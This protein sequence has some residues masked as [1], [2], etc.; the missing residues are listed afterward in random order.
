MFKAKKTKTTVA[1]VAQVDEF[2][3]RSI[4]NIFP[5]KEQL[6]TK[7]LSGERLCF[8]LG[9]DPTG[10]SIHLGHIIPMLSLKRL[11]DMGHETILLIGDFTA[12]I[13]DPTDKTATRKALT[14]KEVVK[15]LKDYK[16]QVSK[17]IKLSGANKTRV[18]FNSRWLSKM[19]FSDVLS[20]ASTTTVDQ[21]LKRD[22]FEK[23]ISDGRPIYI[24][25]FLYPLMQGY[26]S[27]V[28]D[29]DGEVGGNDQTF[30]MLV[31]RDLMKTLK[32][33]EKFVVA[34]K[35]LTDGGGKKMGKTEGNMVSLDDSPNNVFGKVMSWSDD[36]IVGAMESATLL[37]MRK[38]EESKQKLQN[39]GNPK[40]EKIKLA[41]A[42]TE[43][44]FGKNKAEEAAK[45]FEKTFSQKEMPVDA[46]EINTSGTVSVVDELIFKRVVDSKSDLK[47]LADAGAITNLGSG[48]RVSFE[49]INSLK[50]TNLRIGKHRFVK[51]K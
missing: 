47:R 36:T 51:I 25:E 38:I 18:V 5:N 6:K 43:L 9:I 26:D 14:K 11:Q 16:K 44:C 50:D 30:N 49:N 28:L 4:E 2:L 13:G 37:P 33:K 15:N 41:R 29:V 12:M 42:I 46:L 3:N 35:I 10:P 1:N 22:M 34:T 32:N 40:N 21:M 17:I 19:N 31:G 7:L 45:N 39:G 8:Y 23:R 48:E 27:V 24:H 20:L